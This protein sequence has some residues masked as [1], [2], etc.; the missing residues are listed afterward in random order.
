[1]R[2]CMRMEIAGSFSSA[3]AP[4]SAANDEGGADKDKEDDNEDDEEDE[5]LNMPGSLSTRGRRERMRF[6]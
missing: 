4:S 1:M 2:S 5:D 3:E 6:R